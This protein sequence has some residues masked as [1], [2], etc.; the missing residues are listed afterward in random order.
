MSLEEAN[1]AEYNEER[2]SNCLICIQSHY[3]TLFLYCVTLHKH[4]SIIRPE[5]V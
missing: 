3:P 4:L 5:T 2:H 1:P